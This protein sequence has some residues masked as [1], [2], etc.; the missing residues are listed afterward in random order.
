MISVEIGCSSTRILH[1]SPQNNEQGL[2]VNLDLLEESKLIAVIR[3]EAYRHKA[4]YYHNTRVKNK[5]FK[6][7]DLVLRKLEA[8]C[9]IESKGKLTPK[10]DGPFRVTRVIRTNTYH[11]HD[12]QGSSLPMHGIQTTLSC[13]I[14]EF[15]NKE[16]IF[17]SFVFSLNLYFF[18]KTT[19]YRFNRGD[20]P[21]WHSELISLLENNINYIL[22]PHLTV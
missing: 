21:L 11:L 12:S 7:G 17:L 13:I 22:R 6:R 2:K 14:S 3:N 19:S 5:T 16:R 10:R 4:T 15:I 1:F 8:T 20:T 18:L 9:N